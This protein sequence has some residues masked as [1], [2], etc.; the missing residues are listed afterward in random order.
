MTLARHDKRLTRGRGLF[1]GCGAARQRRA[2]DPGS[3][4]RTI[5][6]VSI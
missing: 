4:I 1:P 6:V 5:S 2:A 3:I